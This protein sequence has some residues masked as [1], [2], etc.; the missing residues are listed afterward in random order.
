[1]ARN[2]DFLNTSLSCSTRLTKKNFSG[3]N[4]ESTSLTANGLRTFAYICAVP[5][6][7]QQ[8]PMLYLYAIRAQRGRFVNVTRFTSRDRENCSYPR[9]QKFSGNEKNVRNLVM[10]RCDKGTKWSA[11][12]VIGMAFWLWSV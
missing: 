5:V 1:M 7:P 10:L 3:N 2:G 12:V 8:A 11:H 9:R 6:P 4:E